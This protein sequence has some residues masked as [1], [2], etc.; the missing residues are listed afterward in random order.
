MADITAAMVKEL[1]EKTGVGMMDCKKA[2]NEA[3]GSVDAAVTL[4]RER[5]LA[6]ANKKAD[7]AA[8]EGRIF[9]RVSDDGK[10]GVIAEVS[11][12]TDF[13][14]GNDAFVALGDAL[15][16]AVIDSTNVTDMASI[17]SLTIDG[18]PYADYMP[19]KILQ[20]GENISTKQLIVFQTDNGHISRYTHMNGKIGALVE[21]DGSVDH[22]TSSDVAMHV[23]A[24]A[25][26]HVKKDDMPSADIEAE[27]EILKK[28]VMKEGKPEN[29][30]D[31]IVEGK[32]TKFI[33]DVC[34]LE[35]A[36]VKDPSQS[37]AQILPKDVTV[38][39]F[40]RFDQG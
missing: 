38:T 33:K 6:A 23:A 17:D 21:F 34:L 26:L 15:T 28:Q 37:I 12:E 11:C 32:L 22:A 24:A 36:F 9:T 29:I 7:R 20:L 30:A 3:N 39:R 8:N 14:S 31:K 19:E 40:A 2:L 35:Q 16:N 5:G 25:P 13:V 1:R 18:T 4:L 10:K 27:R